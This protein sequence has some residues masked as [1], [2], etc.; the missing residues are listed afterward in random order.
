[1]NI[2]AV[3]PQKQIS[4][5]RWWIHFI[6]IG[7]YVAAAIPLGL[8]QHR[9]HPALPGTTHGLLIVCAWEIGVFGVIFGLGWLASRA[10]AEDLLLKWRQGWWTIPLGIG[11]SIALRIAVGIIASLLVAILL[12]TGLIPRE[13]LAQFSAEGRTAVERIV[14]VS[15]MQHNRT[16]FWLTITVASFVVAG[17]REEL[18]RSGTL[19][20]MRALWP[21]LFEGRDGQIAGVALIAIVFGLAHLTLGLLP[22]GMAMILG[23]LL[24]IIMV[25]HRSIWPAVIAHGMFDATSFA[26]IPIALQ[27]LHRAH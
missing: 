18:W 3:V 22:V 19:A 9:R 4:R 11:Y 20:A 16:Y 6:L 14:D 25:V 17:L 10:S 1:V 21:T 12:L 8:L 24:G 13:S 15:A 27:H 2:E 26:L 5:F 23:F 7:G